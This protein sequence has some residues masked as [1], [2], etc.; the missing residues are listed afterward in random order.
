MSLLHLHTEG[1]HSTPHPT[2]AGINGP[3]LPA[4]PATLRILR[5]ESSGKESPCGVTC[6]NLPH[7]T[8]SKLKLAHQRQRL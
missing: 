1:G 7:V 8:S 4:A 6:R 5:R 3:E 2:P